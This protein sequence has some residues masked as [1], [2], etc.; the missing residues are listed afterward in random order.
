MI[1]WM[2]TRSSWCP[3]R[4]GR[5]TKCLCLRAPELFVQTSQ[6][7]QAF[8]SDII[9]RPSA[10]LGHMAILNI[11]TSGSREGWLYNPH[12][13]CPCWCSILNVYGDI[14]KI[15]LTKLEFRICICLSHLTSSFSKG[16]ISLPRSFKI[17]N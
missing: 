14:I 11:S 15:T 5:S 10:I 9:F 16:K 7:S 13:H 2:W 6:A 12:V 1:I 17:Q 4:A 8:W 3:R